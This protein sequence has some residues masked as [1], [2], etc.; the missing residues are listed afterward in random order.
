MTM[1]R[2]QSLRTVLAASVASGLLL[3]GC[4]LWDKEPEQAKMDT[5]QLRAPSNNPQFS[6]NGNVMTL[7]ENARAPSGNADMAMGLP[8][9]DLAEPQM[10]QAEPAPAPAPMAKKEE[11]SW[12]SWAWANDEEAVPAERRVPKL[13]AEA[14]GEMQLAGNMASY[15]QAAPVS[16]VNMSADAGLEP[17][18]DI[19][20][21]D[22]VIM[23]DD[24]F[25]PVEQ[26]QMADM[27]LDNGY[28]NLASVPLRPERLD[29]MNE[30]DARMADLQ[31]AR[32]ESSY[33]NQEL[34]AQ[35]QSDA[36]E[37]MMA[38][39]MVAMAQAEAAPAAAPSSID[40]EFAALV[41]ADPMTAEPEVVVIQEEET[42]VVS[43]GMDDGMGM[44]EQEPAPIVMANTQPQPWDAPA[45]DSNWAP[46]P[47]AP[48]AEAQP[49]QP[50]MEQPLAPMQ[51]P[52][53]ENEWVS[54]QQDPA[55]QMEAPVPQVDVASSPDVMAVSAVPVVPVGNEPYYT[56]N[57]G[58]AIAL[59]PPSAM[60][61]SVRT[62]PESRYAARRQAVYMQRYTRMQ[63]GS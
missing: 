13:N 54:L 63:D 32:L 5:S 12:F 11:K 45:V 17:Y 3:S 4:A 46:A 52:I 21:A 16:E 55:M 47:M 6:D 34:Q 35:M 51:Q 53:Q 27:P 56:G 41:A 2:K 58:G 31:N 33:Q 19:V 23:M 37:T 15:E 36:G 25:T 9:E 61:R 39:D 26:P 38:G 28:P 8:V 62:L 43:H 29:A 59:T 44:Y 49:V 40:E 7:P 24:T 20:V 30:K 10:A 57:A 50:V 1:S 18:G 48:Q 14:T 60:G 22:E 42:V